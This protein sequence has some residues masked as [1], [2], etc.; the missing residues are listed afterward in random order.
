MSFFFC[1]LHQNLSY[2]SLPITIF[3]STGNLLFAE[4]RLTFFARYYN[5]SRP[6]E[7]DVHVDL[8]LGNWKLFG[9]ELLWCRLQRHLTGKATG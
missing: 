9:G 7:I 8:G 1:K 6:G 2:F 4:S 5:E 3:Y